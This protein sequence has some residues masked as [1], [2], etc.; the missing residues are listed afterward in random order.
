MVSFIFWAQIFMDLIKITV[1]M[2]DQFVVND[3]INTT[4]YLKMHL[5]ENLFLRINS[6][7]K[8]NENLYS[9]NTDETPA[10]IFFFFGH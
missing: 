3:S 10:Y 4:F 2:I 6:T 7:T 9:T 5:K 1:S 8:I